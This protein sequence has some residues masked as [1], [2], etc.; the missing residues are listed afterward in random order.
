MRVLNYKIKFPPSQGTT[1]F[2]SQQEEKVQILNLNVTKDAWRTQEAAETTLE[3]YCD[4][5]HGKHLILCSAGFGSL[6]K[7][8]KKNNLYCFVGS[9]PPTALQIQLLQFLSFP[10]FTA[11]VTLQKTDRDHK[12]RILKGLMALW[13]YY[14]KL[15][16]STYP[17]ADY[18]GH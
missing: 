18:S 8:W 13:S 15:I 11:F 16:K 12:S 10:L 17:F 7:S 6:K 2:V 3:I 9:P 4:G 1:R 5:C 14:W